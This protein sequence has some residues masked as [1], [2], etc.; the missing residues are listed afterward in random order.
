VARPGGRRVA[1]LVLVSSS[2]RRRDLLAPLVDALVVVA[3]KADETAVATGEDLVRNAVAKLKSAKLD[4]GA[5]A[6]AADT[7]VFLDGKALGKPSGAEDARRML[8][9]LSGRWHDVSTGLAVRIDGKVE[10]ALA[11]T[12]VLFRK[13]DDADIDAYVATGEPLDKAG[14]YGIQGLGGLLVERVEGDRDNVVGLPL[15]TLREMLAARGLALE[16]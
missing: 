7:A 1:K 10:T 6:V 15:G 5:I 13:L 11:T 12:R 8:R 14:A 9:E 16:G 3:N 2:P 4:A